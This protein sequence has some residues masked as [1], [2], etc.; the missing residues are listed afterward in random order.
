MNG[1]EYILLHCQEPILYVIRKQFRHSPTQVTPQADYYIIAGFVYQAPDLNSVINARM[2]TT[3][4]HLLSAFEETSSYMRYHPT[5][6]Y[7]WEFSKDGQN[8]KQKEKEMKERIAKEKAKEDFGSSFQRRR[9]DLLLA[10]LAKK[11]PPKI[12]TPEPPKDVK[13]DDGTK[14]AEKHDVN[15]AVNNSVQN[16]TVGNN[17]ITRDNVRSAMDQPPAKKSRLI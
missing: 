15:N 8:D 12:I 7:S 14:L 16:N 17:S 1:L 6:G 3:T 2:L 9:V 13:N 5:K 10:E 4:Y 11:F